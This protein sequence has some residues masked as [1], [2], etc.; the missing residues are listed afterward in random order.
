MQDVT[1]LV[2]RRQYYAHA[3]DRAIVARLVEIDAPYTDETD[4]NHGFLYHRTNA[5]MLIILYKHRVVGKV[6]FDY[7]QHNDTAD[8]LWLCAPGWGKPLLDKLEYEL[9][10]RNVEEI[11][12]ACSLNYHGEAMATNARRL[13]FWMSN[14][15]RMK[16]MEGY[17]RFHLK[18]SL[19]KNINQRQIDWNNELP[20]TTV[21]QQQNTAAAS[22]TPHT[23]DPE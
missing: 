22:A 8:I 7:H 4:A 17:D 9:S 16:Y 23:N 3:A 6:E 5:E 2:W 11:H 19:A 18:L 10:F 15:Y 20:S 12:L 1:F 13:N 21:A 14:G